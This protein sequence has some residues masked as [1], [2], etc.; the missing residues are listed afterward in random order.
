MWCNREDNLHVGEEAILAELQ[1][2][3]YTLCIQLHPY[4]LPSPGFCA[5]LWVVVLIKEMDFYWEGCT[6]PFI[7]CVKVIQG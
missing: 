6:L 5:E 7:Q 4:L 2:C 1:K 3:D